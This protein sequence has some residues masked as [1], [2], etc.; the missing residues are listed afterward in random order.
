MVSAVGNRHGRKM[1]HGSLTETAA[2]VYGELLRNGFIAHPGVI[3]PKASRSG[4]MRIKVAI[5]PHATRITITGKG[6]QEM[7]IYGMIDQDRL[8]TVL[9]SLK[10]T[11]LTIRRS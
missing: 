8:A 10:P 4:V 3:N 9:R 5:E 2:I 6:A 7:R 1:R 11:D